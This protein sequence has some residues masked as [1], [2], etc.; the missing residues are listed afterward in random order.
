MKITV[1]GAGGSVGGPTAFYLAAQKL[2]DE[3]VLID[4]KDN[5]AKQ[6]AMD[7]STAVAAKGVVVR[8][9]GYGDLEGTDIVINAAGVPRG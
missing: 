1:L 4:Y 2:A 8:A 3:I 6:N 7:L 9:G 5:L